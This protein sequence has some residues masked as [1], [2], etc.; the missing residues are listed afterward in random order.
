[1]MPSHWPRITCD[2]DAR[3]SRFVVDQSSR[4]RHALWKN[5]VGIPVP[6]DGVQRS[7]T[8]MIFTDVNCPCGAFYRRAE[9]STISGKPG[10]FHCGC[11]GVLLESWSEPRQRAYRLVTPTERLYVHPV[12]PPSPWRAS[13]PEAAEAD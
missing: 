9:S 6:A 5:T 1:M 7:E 10:E 2:R 12:P 8:G 11:C 4:R 13:V 3:L